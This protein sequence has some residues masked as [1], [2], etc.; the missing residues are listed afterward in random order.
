MLNPDFLSFYTRY[1]IHLSIG[2]YNIDIKML[3]HERLEL[4]LTHQPTGH[5]ACTALVVTVYHCTAH[6]M[7]D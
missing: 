3:F 1:L 6:A 4:R 2:N 5:F 7:G